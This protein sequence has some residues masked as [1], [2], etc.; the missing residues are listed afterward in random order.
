MKKRLA[1]VI[2]GILLIAALVLGIC[3]FPKDSKPTDNPTK[4]ET[5][6]DTELLLGFESLEEILGA[7]VYLSNLFGKTSINTDEKYITEGESSW[8]IQ[9]NT[10]SKFFRFQCAD[11]TFGTD[12]F[13]NYDEILMDIYNASD[14]KAKIQWEFSMLNPDMEYEKTPTSTYVLEPNTWT[15]C[16]FDLSVVDYNLYFYPDTVGYMRVAFVD[17]N[18]DAE[19]VPYMLYVDNLRGHLAEES[20][21]RGEVT[22][23]VTE[24]ITFEPAEERY[25]FTYSEAAGMQRTSYANAGIKPQDESHGEYCLELNA[26]GKIWPRYILDMGQTFETDMIVKYKLYVKVDENLVEDGKFLIEAVARRTGSTKTQRLPEVLGL[27][28]NEWIEVETYLP[29]GESILSSYV[30]LEKVRGLGKSRFASDVPV[31][32]YLDNFIVSA[33][34]AGV[35][36]QDKIVEHADGSVTLYESYNGDN[37]VSYT[38]KQAV[39]MGQNY[40]VTVE[41]EEP[42][43]AWVGVFGIKDGKEKEIFADNTKGKVFS[44]NWPAKEDWEALRVMVAFRDKTIDY[45]KKVVTLKGFAIKDADKK[46]VADD[47]TVTVANLDGNATVDHT[48]QTPVKAGGWYTVKVDIKEA[49][50]VWVGVFGRKDGTEKEIFADN[51]N[52]GT[53]VIKW[54]AKEDWDSLR[55]MVAFRDKEVD[56]SK[57]VVTFSEFKVT[58]PDITKVEDDTVTIINKDENNYVEYTY[59]TGVK[60]GGWYTVKVDIKEAQQV[61]VGV[62]GRKDGT[63]KEIFADNTNKGTYVIKWQAKEDWDSL[64]VMVAFRDKE[65]DWS[66]NVVTFSEFKVTVPDITKVEGDT[67][68]LINK[69]ENNYVEYTYEARVNADGWYTVKVALSEAESRGTWIGVFGVNGNSETQIFADNTTG[70]AYTVKYQAKAGYEKLK[71]MV[72]NFNE[73]NWGEKTVTLT[74]FKVTDPDTTTVTDGTITLANKDGNNQV[75]YVFDE[76]VKVGDKVKFDLTISPTGR[77]A[78]FWVLGCDT[79]VDGWKNQWWG[80]G[81]NTYNNTRTFTIP[82]QN[83]TDVFTL[84]VQF[85]DTNVDFSEHIVTISNFTIEEATDPYNFAKGVSF[86]NTVDIS[87]F[88]GTNFTVSTVSYESAG[89]AKPTAQSGNKVLKAIGNGDNWPRVNI[90]LDK[91][92]PVGSVFSVW[93]YAQSSEATDTNTYWTEFYTA[94]TTDYT[95]A[96]GRKFNQWVKYEVTLSKAASVARVR[97]NLEYSKLSNKAVTVYMDDFKISPSGATAPSDTVLAALSGKSALFVGDSIMAGATDNDCYYDVKSW[98]GRIGYYCNMDVTNNGVSGACVSNIL[99]STN[100]TKYIYNNLVKATDGDYDYVIMHGLYNDWGNGAPLGTAQGMANFNPNTADKSQFAQALEYLFY[101]A[102]Q[103]HPNAQLGFIVNFKTKDG[104]TT[105]LYTLKAIEICEDWGIPYIDL[106]HDSSF[107]IDLSDGLHPSTKGYDDTYLKIAEWMADMEGYQNPPRNS[108]TENADGTVTYINKVGNFVERSFNVSALN[109]KAGDTVSVTFNLAQAGPSTVWSAMFINNAEKQADNITGTKRTI[110]VTLTEDCTRL[111]VLVKN[112]NVTD[113]DNTITISDLTISRADLVT[114]NPD[115]T[116]TVENRN[117]NWIEYRFD[118]SDKNLKAGDTVSVTFN[119]ATPE[120][121]WSALFVNGNEKQADN[122]NGTRTITVTLTEDC[123]SL[124]ILV[125]N[126]NVTEWNNAVTIQPLVI[127]Q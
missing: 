127:T 48:Y 123:T 60:A 86:E 58:E 85:E 25:A 56:W 1:I 92:Y 2:T 75:Q 97:L 38:F 15:T 13:S 20:L 106:Y 102:K 47:G 17:G 22:Y 18:G 96:P 69:D 10:E 52:K 65:V 112:F 115:G 100:N 68:T 3:L 87:A 7:K 91:E 27:P 61:W 125:K 118:V 63:E 77:K 93:V 51:T 49:Q 98:P 72:K 88:V 90:T 67:V 9:P 94:D 45:T 8:F 78:N 59:D 42:Q 16:K 28:Y 36:L 109:L 41:F 26:Q 62:F 124:W 24:G 103:Q 122:V 89:V 30:N 37:A 126:F 46:T 80:D 84:L 74:N 31:L 79:A 83:A 40:L 33:P 105:S 12:D 81:V 107:D 53:Y 19:N 121:V 104:A 14:E 50:Q 120:T 117:G 64:R 21:E 55:V 5:G 71:V 54:Q 73:T 116:V 29:A 70:T 43:Q 44:I 110:T 95:N 76:D 57:N 119:L 39:K 66:K 32:V 11:S 35:Y 6:K 101:T 113:W 111:W 4:V 108:I 99:E 23:D 34:G 82:A 114:E